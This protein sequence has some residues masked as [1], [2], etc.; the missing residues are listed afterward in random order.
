MTRRRG[1]VA[2][3]AAVPLLGA[4]LAGCGGV[5][6][7]DLPIPGGGV[8]GPSYRLNAV[9]ADALNL[10]GGAHVK[11]NGDDIGRVEQIIAKD[12]TARV[13]MAVRTDVSLPQGSTAELRQ[14]TPL[15][16][17]FVAI[18]PPEHPPP[19]RP[20]RDGDTIGLPDTEAGASVEDLLASLSTL[21]NG[22]GLAQIQTIVQELNAATDGRAPQI[23]HLLG[24]TT[25]TMT[26]LNA[27]TADIDRVLAASQRLTDT[28]VAR[29]DTIDKAF[30][31]FTPAIKVLADQ[32]DRF[33][34]ALHKAGK[35]SDTGDHIID[36]SGS[37]IR[38]LT[39]D[40]GPV[41]DGF[42][43][44][45][46]NLS[47]S[48]R[49]LVALGKSIEQVTKGES[50]AG[51]ANL[52]LLPLPIAIPQPGDNLPGPNDFVDGEQSFAQHL[53]HQFSTL[54]GLR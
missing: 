46:P 10:P 4:L 34:K 16:E 50:L 1:P 17:V 7:T 8:D 19:G 45:G 6:A 42:A 3:L 33:T 18:H 52:S 35:V 47:P 26:T 44:I 2:V 30:A 13:T 12:Y 24:Q 49:D 20:L 38:S 27:R 54:G 21:V 22:G 23:A 32:T 5:S 51:N 25:Q 53:E 28:L 11:L 43:R 40:L 14:A 48:L 9:F 15:G 29:R 36:E 37:D 31:D 41:L 39:R